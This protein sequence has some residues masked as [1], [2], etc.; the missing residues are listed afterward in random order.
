MCNWIAA[1]CLRYRMSCAKPWIGLI[2]I[3]DQSRQISDRQICRRY[4]SVVSIELST[5]R[6]ARVQIL[7]EQI[8]RIRQ[9]IAG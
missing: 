3:S 6:G 7:Q 2:G 4:P 5:Q 8:D 1:I 9:V